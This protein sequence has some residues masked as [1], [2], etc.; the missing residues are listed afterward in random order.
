MQWFY[1]DDIRDEVP[2]KFNAIFVPDYNS[3]IKLI[4]LCENNL[5]EFGISFSAGFLGETDPT[6]Y[7]IA[8]YLEENHIAMFKGFHIHGWD[9]N[10]N[11]VRS[12]LERNG[13]EEFLFKV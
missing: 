11:K 10:D 7:S 13:Y 6:S 1:F 12:Y 9:T 3:M 2:G 4:N 8:K 5:I